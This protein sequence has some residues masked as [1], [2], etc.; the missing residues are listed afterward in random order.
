MELKLRRVSARVKGRALA[1][2]MGV[3][4]SRVSALEREA[5]VSEVMVSRYLAALATLSNVRSAA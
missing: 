1:S 5:V 2:E 4:P 3:T